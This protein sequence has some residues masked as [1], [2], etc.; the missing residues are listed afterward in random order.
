[1]KKG[2]QIKILTGYS[3]NNDCVFCGDKYNRKI[4]DKET[5]EV[6]REIEL[7]IKQGGKILN[8]IGGE[9][10]IR[11]DILRLI[12]FAREKG[13]GY[14]SITTNGR[15]LADKKFASR[16]IKA[17][18]TNMIVTVNGHNADM[19]DALANRSGCYEQ[20]FRGIENLLELGFR[21]IGTN[22]VILKKNYKNIPDI[23]EHL[24]RWKVVRA[25]L[26]YVKTTYDFKKLTPKISE[27][28][29]YI[30]EFLDMSRLVPKSKWHVLNLPMYC[31]SYNYLEHMEE[32][33]EDSESGKDQIEFIEIRKD[34]IEAEFKRMIE[35]TKI[36]IC[37]DCAIKD[38]CIGIQKSYLDNFGNKEVHPVIKYDA[39]S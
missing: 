34:Y 26:L 20:S 29:P 17:G 3:C 38:K 33:K 11:P 27:I 5:S 12:S 24:I 18:V 22:T 8:L 28:Y 13:F 4:R 23:A 39:K 10:T 14:I 36:G 16:L 32:T 30:H 9:L 1:M 6:K 15:L 2:K 19:Q 37:R 35:R 7:G 31:Y 25:A 21:D